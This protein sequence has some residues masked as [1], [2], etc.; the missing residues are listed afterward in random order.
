MNQMRLATSLLSWTIQQALNIQ[1][2]AMVILTIMDGTFYGLGIVQFAMAL[3]WIF[4]ACCIVQLN[5]EV[6][7]LIWFIV[8]VFWSCYSGYG[9]YGWT[10]YW[11]GDGQYAFLYFV[12]FALYV[13]AVW[14]QVAATWF[15]FFHWQQASSSAQRAPLVADSNSSQQG[16]V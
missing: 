8:M 9:A 13:F 3:F 16:R 2:R 10:G 1:N 12:F 5:N 7:N 4:I 11:G 6:A 14:V 15:A